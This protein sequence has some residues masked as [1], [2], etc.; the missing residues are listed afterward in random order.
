M[1]ADSSDNTAN[2]ILPFPSPLI[3]LPE[4]IFCYYSE[5]F[6]LP[7]KIIG[8]NIYGLGI[9]I[10]PIIITTTLSKWL[11]YFSYEYKNMLNWCYI[12]IWISV[13]NFILIVNYLWW[14]LEIFKHEVLQKMKMFSSFLSWVKIVKTL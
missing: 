4:K 10:C 13:F 14:D 9:W 1:S 7:H 8:L 5:T 6:S 3:F 2:H 12:Q 11:L